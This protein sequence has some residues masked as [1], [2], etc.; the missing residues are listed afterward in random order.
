MDISGQAPLPKTEKKRSKN[1]CNIRPY[2]LDDIPFL[3][4]GAKK[5]IHE[6]PNYKNITISERRLDY[7]LRHNHGSASHFQCWVLVDNV[8]NELVGAG[9]GYCVPGMATFDLVANDTFLFVHPEWRSMR[10]VVMLMTAYKQWAMAR[11][12]KMI[13]A[14]QTGGYRVGAM[15]EIMRRQGYVEAGFQWML[16]LDDAYLNR[17]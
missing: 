9:A 6:L 8:T 5:Y 17:A 10:N 15:N 3:C 16:R 1:E 14:T 11:G 12:A 4:A 2:A 7:L 13:M